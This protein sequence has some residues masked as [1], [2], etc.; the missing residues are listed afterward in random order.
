MT[1]PKTNVPFPAERDEK[2]HFLKRP[3]GI[4]GFTKENAAGYSKRRWEKYREAAA[5]AI[6][7]EMGSIKPGIFTPES[8]W[9]VLNARLASQI[10]D[11]NKPRGDDLRLLGQNMGAIPNVSERT[12]E[13]N[14]EPAAALELAEKAIDLMDRVFRDVLRL[15]QADPAPEIIDVPATDTRNG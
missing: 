13:E 3:E 2:G 1:P 6:V 8:A 4:V 15:Q 5:D 10:M 9:G 12:L 14:S 7:E 11:S